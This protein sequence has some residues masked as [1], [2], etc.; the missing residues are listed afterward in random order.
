MHFSIPNTPRRRDLH[1]LAGLD[2]AVRD[3]PAS[4]YSSVAVW[5]SL[6]VRLC[7]SS[8]LRALYHIYSF[9]VWGWERVCVP[10]CAVCVRRLEEKFHKSFLRD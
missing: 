9:I 2:L 1:C 6:G 4:N 8:S 5:L 7:E 3:L 10:L